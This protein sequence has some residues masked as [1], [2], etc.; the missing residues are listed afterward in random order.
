MAARS[1][2]ILVGYDGTESSRRA[3]A[4]AADLAGYGSTVS[5]AAIAGSN[6]TAV[7]PAVLL[8]EAREELLRRQVHA[9]YLE[10]IGAG[11]VELVETADELDADLVVVG[12]AGRLHSGDV[13]SSAS[14]DV[15]IVG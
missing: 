9:R 8:R 4:A 15:L 6:G 1:R 7:D 12:R 10:P 3:L 11:A 14:C 2:V 13:A 5:V